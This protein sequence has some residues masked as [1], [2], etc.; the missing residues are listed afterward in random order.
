MKWLDEIM[1]FKVEIVATLKVNPKADGRTNFQIAAI[2][3]IAWN[4]INEAIPDGD[5]LQEVGIISENVSVI[6]TSSKVFL[7]KN[8]K[9]V[10]HL[11]VLPVSKAPYYLRL[12]KKVEI[13]STRGLN[14]LSLMW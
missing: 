8:R 2:E 14:L 9:G 4:A 1:G 12:I 7:F 3:T 11:K 10:A 13:C 5:L 6:I